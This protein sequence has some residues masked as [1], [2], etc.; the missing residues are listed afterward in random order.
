MIITPEEIKEIIENA[1]KRTKPFEGYVPAAV[2]MLFFEKASNT[3]LVYIR[4]THGMNIHSGHMAFPGGKIDPEDG[5]SKVTATREAFEEIGVG[6]E[7]YDYLGD[8]GFF[9]TIISKHDAAA[10]VAW[11]PEQPTYQPSDFE[12]AEIIEIP[13]EILLQQFRADLDF[14]NFEEVKYLN[15]SYS[16]P[17]SA[18]VCNLWGL[19]ARITHHFLAGVYELR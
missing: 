3:H 8:L 1:P 2:L 5:S 14:A 17:G 16:P 11:C 15:F 4:R 13:L 9:E 19:T 6:P 18:E 12:V 7:Q 10:H